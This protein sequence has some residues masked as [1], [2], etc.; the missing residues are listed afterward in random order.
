VVTDPNDPMSNATYRAAVMAANRLNIQLT[1]RREGREWTV[2]A[3]YQDGIRESITVTG[4]TA[5]DAAWHALAAVK[6]A[7]GPTS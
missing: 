1:A 2:Q 7:A 6:A 3:V 4:R 5:A